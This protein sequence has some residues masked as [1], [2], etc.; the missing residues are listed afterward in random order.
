MTWITMSDSGNNPAPSWPVLEERVE[1]TPTVRYTLRRMVFGLICRIRGHHS[2]EL[3][4]EHYHVFTGPDVTLSGLPS[5]GGVVVGRPVA[6]R[7]ERRHSC[8]TCW[9]TPGD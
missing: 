1:G 8:R 3:A 5:T 9:A 7:S 2:L 6:G 4:V